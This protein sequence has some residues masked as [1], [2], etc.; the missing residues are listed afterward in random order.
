MGS[1]E[2]RRGVDRERRG[3]KRE[4]SRNRKRKRREREGKLA[5]R[6]GVGSALAGPTGDSPY[7][8]VAFADAN[9]RTAPWP[10]PKMPT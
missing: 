10:D 6:V 8:I 2:R 3:E 5:S 9:R 7:F 4:G 1:L